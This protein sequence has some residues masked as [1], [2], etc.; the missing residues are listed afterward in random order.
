MSLSRDLLRWYD[1][2]A[3][4]LPWRGTMDP[5]RIWLSEIMLQQTRTET[6][7]P[8]Y[9]QF[10]RRF[11]T[12][13]DLAKADEQEILKLWEGLGYYSRARNLHAAARVVADEMNGMFPC[14]AAELKRLPGVGP[15]AANAIASIAWGE[16]VPALDGNQARVLARVLAW[17]D[18]IS[19]PFDLL[20]PAIKMMDRERP[21]DY[22]QALMDLGAAICTAKAPHCGDCPVARHC[23]ALEE[24]AVQ[25]YPRRSVPMAKKQQD[26]TI[27]LVFSGGKLLVRQRPKGLLGG[28]YEFCPVEGHLSPEELTLTLRQMGFAGP[29]VLDTLPDAKHVFTH[30]IWLMKGYM[31]ECVAAPEG[32]IPVDAAGLATLPFPSALRVYREIAKNQLGMRNEE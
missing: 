10:L 5:Y 22:N 17:E 1:E 15:Y 21:G 4:E 23:R 32:F 29:C 28:L 3:R 16:P 24:D 26:W 12:V 11:P 14:C 2:N 31:A 13:F 20:E 30:R 19:T 9:S 6:V 18:E 8:Y 25:D 7:K 27:L